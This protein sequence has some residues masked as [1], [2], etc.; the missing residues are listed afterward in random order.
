MLLLA[1]IAEEYQM[2]QKTS[3]K[4]RMLNQWKGKEKMNKLDAK[5]FALS[6]GVLWGVGCLLMGLMAI[7]C[8]W[9]QPF[10]N[11]IGVMYV[12]YKATVVGSLVGAA[13][14]FIDGAIG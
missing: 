5:A 2:N 4:I 8:P 3:K 14:G 1:N 11:F 7:V 10:V 12:G 9:A 13:W 6:I